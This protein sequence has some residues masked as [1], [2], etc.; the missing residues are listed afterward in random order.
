LVGSRVGRKFGRGTLNKLGVK[1]RG[2]KGSRLF[3]GVF[4][5]PLNLKNELRCSRERCVVGG[6]VFFVARLSCEFGNTVCSSQIQYFAGKKKLREGRWVGKKGG[7]VG[8]K[9]GKSCGKVGEGKKVRV[10]A[11]G[12]VGGRYCCVVGVVVGR[13]CPRV[14]V[15]QCRDPH[16]EILLYRIQKNSGFPNSEKWSPH[17]TIHDFPLD[18]LVFTL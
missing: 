11:L 5:C 16:E 13:N 1:W 12:G 15:A 10:S 14:W 7:K 17:I 3:F 9:S 6:C 8:E 18:L 4:L 2:E